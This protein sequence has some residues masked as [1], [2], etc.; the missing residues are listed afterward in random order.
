MSRVDALR[1]R[2]VRATELGVPGNEFLRHELQES[3][4]LKCHL[5]ARLAQAGQETEDALRELQHEL[6]TPE[7]SYARLATRQAYGEAG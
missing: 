6:D 4:A 1:A 2:L 7:D 5:N 3:Q